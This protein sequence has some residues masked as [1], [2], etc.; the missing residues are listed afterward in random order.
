MKNRIFGRILDFFASDDNK[1]SRRSRDMQRHT[2]NLEDFSESQFM[3][4]LAPA[5]ENPQTEEQFTT[6]TEEE[7]LALNPPDLADRMVKSDPTIDKIV[8][9]F[10]IYAT[11]DYD[12]SCED[13]RGDEII[14]EFLALLTEKRNGFPQLLVKAFTSIILRGEICAE[15]VFD[16]SYKASNLFIVDTQYLK[17]EQE[18]DP[19]DGQ[20]WV[21]GQM[22]NGK[23][24]KI[25]SPTVIFESINPLLKNPRGRSM[26]A[27]SFPSVISDALMMQDLRKVVKSHAW[28]QRM[29]AINQIALYQAGFTGDQI[30]QIVADDKVMIEQEWKQLGPGETPIGT[31]EI[32]FRQYEGAGG[33]R[34]TFVDTLDRVYDRK[35]IRGGKATPSMLGSN[36]FTAESSA[37]EQSVQ[38]SMRVSSHQRTVERVFTRIFTQIIRSEGIAGKVDFQ[39]KRINT[40]ERKREAETFNAM[41]TGIKTAIDA[42]I[43]LKTA[44]KMYQ[45]VTGFHFS[46]ELLQDIEGGSTDPNAMLDK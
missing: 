24:E 9:D 31:G 5:S 10:T 8:D 12:Y 11:I 1:S 13:S 23:F 45:E 42:S 15:I 40:R 16:D 41:I 7:L 19:I 14:A 3:R 46:A 25:D 18:K 22:R 35:T 29:I 32:E 30:R 37:E 27:S 36:E 34:L 21:L 20:V 44:V 26:I 39:L 38:Y 33:G 2:V 43:P 28:T 17:V 6:M 4:V